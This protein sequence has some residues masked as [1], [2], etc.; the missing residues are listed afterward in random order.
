MCLGYLKAFLGLVT[1]L[2]S[3]LVLSSDLSET[4]LLEL[5]LT[6]ALLMLSLYL[7][8][9]HLGLLPSPPSPSAFRQASPS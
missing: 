7:H 9:V 6:R 8:N 5:G 4:L 1:D 3:T 2:D